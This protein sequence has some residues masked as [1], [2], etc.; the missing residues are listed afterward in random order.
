VVNEQNMPTQKAANTQQRRMRVMPKLMRWSYPRADAVTAISVGVAEDLARVTGLQDERIRIIYNP[1]VTSELQERA[2]EGVDDTWLG[3]DQPPVILGVG[4]L[5][6]Q[7]DFSTLL[8]AFAL[9]RKRIKVRLIIIGEGEQRNALKDLGRELGVEEEVRL[10]GF[11][12]NPY[13]YMAR[14]AVFAL[15]SKWEGLGMALIEAMACGTPVVSTDCPSGPREILEK[16]RWG[17]LVP[18]GSV[19]SLAQAIVETVED[20]GCDPQRRAAYFSV[21]AAVDQY[22]QLLYG[23]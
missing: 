16:G 22:L 10:P 1:V 5:V 9:A 2:A 21:Q 8:R 12:T 4:R 23:E 14:S 17:R 11:V 19:E 6:K 20:P 7:K 3:P 13:A 15:S 18:V